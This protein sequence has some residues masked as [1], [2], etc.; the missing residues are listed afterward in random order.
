MIPR[1]KTLT[2][3][4]AGFST[5]LIARTGDTPAMDLSGCQPMMIMR[6]FILQTPYGKDGWQ[7]GANVGIF[8]ARVAGAPSSGNHIFEN[9]TIGGSYKIAA[10]FSWDSEENRYYNCN[11]YNHTGDAFIC[12]DHN[13]WGLKSPYVENDESSNAEHRFYGTRFL[14]RG[15]G[16]VGLRLCGGQELSINGG[17]ISMGEG[18]FAGIYLDGTYYVKSVSLCDIRMEGQGKH[19]LYAVGGVSGVLIEGGEWLTWKDVILYENKITDDNPAHRYV[20]SKTSEGRAQNWTIRNLASRLVLM[21]DAEVTPKER[22]YCAM[23]FE[24]LQDSVIEHFNLRGEYKIKNAEGKTDTII[25]TDVPFVVV[26]KYS[27]RNVFK[28]PSRESVVLKGDAENN[29]I[30]ALADGTNEKVPALWM[31][32]QSS[33]WKEL[34]PMFAP[35]Y[36]DGISRTYIKPDEGVSLLNLGIMD[37]RK[38]KS[39]KAGDIAIHDGSGLEDGK[40]CLV[41]F[42]GKKWICGA[43]ELPL[44]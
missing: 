9:V 2:F 19:G 32:H 25:A 27:R 26:E 17:F 22:N 40:A 23:R 34:V 14:T 36:Y 37:V 12:T 5:I 21:E 28:V 43:T 39:P 38:I 8:M 6:N 29:Q 18:S 24:S 11:F 33:I 7:Q 3:E 30:I 41:M 16:G 13:P 4:G 31:S 35:R 20:F 44:E 1:Y 42:D 10:V 15:E